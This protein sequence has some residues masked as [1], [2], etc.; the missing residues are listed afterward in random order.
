MLMEMLKTETRIDRVSNG[1]K[2]STEVQTWRRVYWF[3]GGKAHKTQ[4]K[5]FKPAVIDCTALDTEEQAREYMTEVARRW[6][7]DIN[8]CY[9]FS[10]E[11]TTWIVKHHRNKVKG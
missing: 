4:F 2:Y 3:V 9:V 11:D 1:Y 10:K 8:Q 6:G 7:Y 5:T